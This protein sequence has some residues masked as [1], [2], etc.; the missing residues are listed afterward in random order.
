M[1]LR[2]IEITITWQNRLQSGS[3]K[4]CTRLV[5][6]LSRSSMRVLV[7]NYGDVRV[8]KDRSLVGLP[9]YIIE[10]IDPDFGLETHKSFQCLV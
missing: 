9:R 3:E 8:F 2:H 4:T 1:Q 7:E 5:A 6:R 10:T